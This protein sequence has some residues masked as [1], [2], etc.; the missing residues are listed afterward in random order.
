MSS[1]SLLSSFVLFRFAT[2]RL[3]EPKALPQF[4]RAVLFLSGVHGALSF[5]RV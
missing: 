1:K 4:I 5:L 2:I 3:G